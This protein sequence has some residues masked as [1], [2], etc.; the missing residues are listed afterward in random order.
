[1]KLEREDIELLLEPLT[2]RFIEALKPILSANVKRDIEPDT[3]YDVKGL[4]EYLKVK[5]KWVYERTHLN[6]IPFLKIG[7]QLRFRKKSIDKWLNSFE[8][9]AV[10]Q[11]S[12][13]L[14]DRAHR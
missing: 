6:E 14:P 9:P 8:T 11:F 2:E 7:A 5:E 3:I 1:M 13:K 4:C 12:G 10:N